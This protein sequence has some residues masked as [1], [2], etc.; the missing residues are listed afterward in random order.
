MRPKSLLLIVIALGCG[1]VASIGISQ[2]IEKNGDGE[3]QVPE[4]SPILVAKLDIPNGES[5]TVAAVAL[6]EWPV[7]KIPEGALTSVEQLDGRRARQPLFEGEPIVERKLNSGNTASISDRIATGYRVQSVKVSMDSAVSGLILPGDR[8]D[9]M[10]F[11]EKNREIQR[12]MTKTILTDVTVFAINDQ[13]SRDPDDGEGSI[14]AKTVSLLV[15]PDQAEKLMLAARLGEISLSLRRT[16]DDIES[17]LGQGA[18]IDDFNISDSAAQERTA[19][20]GNPGGFLD[21]MNTPPEISK[22]EKE[23][24]HQMEVVSPR[25]VDVYGFTDDGKLPEVIESTG[26]PTMSGGGL[27]PVTGLEPSRP[28]PSTLDILRTSTRFGTNFARPFWHEIC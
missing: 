5:I 19:P 8:V 11:L 23:Y 16:G 26:T 20:D 21:L 3:D 27:P 17:N 6:E 13:I 9:V 12:T 24:G 28:M 15:K 14:T 4:T 10:V 25:G 22:V 2:V 18:G 7:T 1:L